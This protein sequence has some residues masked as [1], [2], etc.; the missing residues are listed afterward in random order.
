MCALT[1]TSLISND[2]VHRDEMTAIT[3]CCSIVLHVTVYV[4]ISMALRFLQRLSA[5]MNKYSFCALAD[6]MVRCAIQC[7]NPNGEEIKIASFL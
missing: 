5:M 1:Q 3:V 6:K 4:H 7:P 2:Y